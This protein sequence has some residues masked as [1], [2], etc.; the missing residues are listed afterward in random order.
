MNPLPQPNFGSEMSGRH[1]VIVRVLVFSFVW[2]GSFG[3]SS[4]SSFSWV[5]RDARKKNRSA[6]H[7]RANKR[8]ISELTNFPLQRGKKR[9]IQSL[10][11]LVSNI[12]HYLFIYLFLKETLILTLN[13]IKILFELLTYSSTY[14]F[15]CYISW[16]GRK[17]PSVN[18]EVNLEKSFSITLGQIC[19]YKSLR[20]SW[21]RLGR[22]LWNY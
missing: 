2:L 6:F 3:L 22:S 5:F 15:Y 16:K 13:C 21:E 9:M 19:F 7:G 11:T 17:I 4:F 18:H 1:W 8:I 10:S 12:F 14:S 20:R